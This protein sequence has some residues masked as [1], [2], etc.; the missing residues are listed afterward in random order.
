MSYPQNVAVTLRVLSRSAA[1]GQACVKVGILSPANK[2]EVFGEA[3]LEGDTSIHA[4][5]KLLAKAAEIA[6]ARARRKLAQN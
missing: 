5:E 6:W 4:F 2:P 1:N 3:T